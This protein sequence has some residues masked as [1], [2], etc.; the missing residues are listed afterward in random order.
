MGGRA[1]AN[2]RPAGPG[3]AAGG[4]GPGRPLP[5]WPYG[6]HRRVHASWTA[7]GVLAAAPLRDDQRQRQAGPEQ[8]GGCDWQ[9]IAYPAQIRLKAELF[10]AEFRR[11][12]GVELETHELIAPAPAEFGYRAR[13]RIRTGPGGKVGYRE[14]E[15]HRLV[16]ITRCLVAA[17]DV[18]VA[19]ELARALGG[20]CDEIEVV[21]AAHGHVL[22]AQLRRAPT[23]RAA[24]IAGQ[25][26]AADPRI[27]GVILYSGTAR[28]VV[29][30]VTL[31]VEPEPGCVLKAAA[32]RFTQVNHPQNVKLVATVMEFARLERGTPL[33]DL[34]CGAGNFSIPAARR[35]AVVTGVD[36]DAL[37]V[38]DARENAARMRLHEAQFIAMAAEETARFLQR[39]RYRPAGRDPRSATHWRGRAD[40]DGRDARGAARDLRLLRSANLD[41]RPRKAGRHGYRVARVRG[42]DFFPNTHHIEAVAE[43]LLT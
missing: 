17:G 19:R 13:I 1:D 40:G 36:A 18:G 6:R 10:A 42:F 34:F 39:A 29:G 15:S 22:I 24:A 30:D 14:L 8:C 23:A 3:S 25:A 2:R 28:V 41:P 26:M 32:D 11:G 21:V 43:L 4:R 12:L 35:G 27:A 16:A 37:A 33:L 20:G 7:C 38:A 9:Q 31:A 5:R